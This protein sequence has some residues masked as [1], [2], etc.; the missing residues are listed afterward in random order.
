MR[1]SPLP[2][3]LFIKNRSK[4]KGWVQKGGLVIVTS[5]DEMPTN[6]DGVMGFV[7][8]SD[9]FYLTGISQPD[10]FFIFFPS[11]P[12]PNFREV[13]FIKETDEQIAIWEGQKYTKEQAREISGIQEVFWTHEF[14][15]VLKQIVFLAEVIYLNDNEHPRQH[16]VVESQQRRMISKVKK[17]YPLH[18][19]KRLAPIM[20]QLRMIKELEEI[21]AIREAIRITGLGFSK[22]LNVLKHGVYEYE[23]EGELSSVFIKNQA[24]GFAYSPIIASG[25]SACVL[26]Y[27]SNHQVCQAG[28]LVLLDIGANYA[29][30]NADLTRT[31]PVS[32]TFSPRQRAVYDAVLRVLNFA[33]EMLRPGTLL[34]EYNKE[35]GAY[36]TS[37]L[38]GLGLL[39]RNE[40]KM[41]DKNKPLYRKYFMHGTSHHLGL[42]VHDVALEYMP[43]QEGMVLTIEPGI[44]MPEEKIGVRLENNVLIG[45]DHNVNLMNSIPIEADE[46][47][48][49]MSQHWDSA[50]TAEDFK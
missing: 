17:E 37:E 50:F 45:V 2:P 7:Q 26:H 30:Y 41:Q 22:V 5:N 40:V 49:I 44:Y 32:G 16:V 4:L 33:N 29:N 1:S 13:L 23:L 31:V 20:H 38:I 42:D 28:D 47:E 18:D 10:T 24:R 43:I 3:T 36:M 21:E 19:L 39:N 8:Q 48:Q 15:Q 9:L 12:N 46:I 34:N 11:H 6:G 14:E 35:V 27:T 25:A